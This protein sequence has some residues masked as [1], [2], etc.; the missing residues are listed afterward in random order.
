MNSNLRIDEILRSRDWTLTEVANKMDLTLAS[1]SASMNN[2]PTLKQLQKVAGV[3]ES[4]LPDL[5]KPKDSII[6]IISFQDIYSNICDYKIF[7]LKSLKSALKKIE[8]S[9]MSESETAQSLFENVKRICSEKDIQLNE[10][11]IQMNTSLQNLNKFLQGNPRLDTLERIATILDVTVRDLFEANNQAHING[12]VSLYGTTHLIHSVTDVKALRKALVQKTTTN[13]NELVD[14]IMSSVLLGTVPQVI[15]SPDINIEDIILDRIEH[16]D[17]TNT[18]C[19]SYRKK[20]DVRDGIIINLGNMV[21]GYPFSVL[22]IPF[23]DSECA[24]IAGG[25]SNKGI[26]YT[27]IQ[28]LLSKYEKGGYNAKRE[29][30]KTKNEVTSLFRKDWETFNIDWMLFIIWQKCMTNDDFKKLLL[31]IPRNAQILE[32]T[33]YHHGRT[34]D[35][36]G[37]KNPI[38]TKIRQKKSDRFKERMLE[39][40]ICNETIID[41]NMQIIE[42]RINAYGIWTGKNV[43]G[44]ILKICQLAL[45]DNTAPPINYKLLRNSNIYWFGSLLD[46]ESQ[47]EGYCTSPHEIRK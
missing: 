24:Y 19:W 26:E 13:V 1:L 30:R 27:A 9:C 2:N 23:N 36:W 39:K 14:E 3:L 10:I 5:L 28:E 41:E 4:K 12:V 42:N 20:G 38:L 21:K 18:N 11:A 31:S 45:M 7:D 35:I 40:G 15:S 32:D 29:Y 47:L 44:K 46:F 34:S 25:Y 16:Y 33:S 17:A 22:G 43:M 6:G 37:A 8:D